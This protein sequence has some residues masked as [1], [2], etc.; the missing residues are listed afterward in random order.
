[1]FYIMYK[2]IKHYSTSVSLLTDL[3]LTDIIEKSH[4]HLTRS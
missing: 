1:M 4:D 3:M 2:I